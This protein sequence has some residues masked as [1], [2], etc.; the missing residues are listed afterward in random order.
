VLAQA[1]AG[2]AAGFA[3]DSDILAAAV[4]EHRDHPDGGERS[5]PGNVFQIP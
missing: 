2:V 1:A 4:R 5:T 3:A